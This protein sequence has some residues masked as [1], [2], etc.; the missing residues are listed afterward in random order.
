VQTD[1]YGL[2]ATLHQM[3]TGHDPADSPFHFAPLRSYPEVLQL[4]LL[5]KQLVE[6]NVSKR[7]A[8]AALVRQQLQ[9]IATHIQQRSSSL[10]S[11]PGTIPI[12]AI[13]AGHVM[14]SPPGSRQAGSRAAARTIVPQ[15]NTLFT[16]QGHRSRITSLAW[17][18]DGRC[19]ASSSY[20]KTARLWDARN[21]K[22]V[23]LYRGHRARVNALAWSPDGRHLA[24][25][26]S[27]CS[28]QI[29]EAASGSHIFTYR[30]HTTEVT[31]LAWSPDGRYLAS[32]DASKNV[33]VW[34]LKPQRTFS[35]QSTHAGSIAALGW[36]PDGRRLACA[37]ANKTLQ[38]WDPLKTQRSGFLLNLLT[39]ART[40]ILYT[41][42]N[43]HIQ[44]V[45][46]SPDGRHIASGG[47]DKTLQIWDALTGRRTFLY[48]NR[49]A[50]INTVAWSPDQTLLAF[51]SND[52][53][54]QVWNVT[55]RKFIATY[56]GHIHYVTSLAWSPDSRCIS[57][58]SVDRTI[59]VWTVER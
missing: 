52:R 50:T 39:S 18:P 43:G 15:K 48:S 6:I 34:Q 56:Q 46:W 45:H 41:G 32:G 53:T 27:D 36:S 47:T 33:Q 8:S 51:G 24:S 11:G 37:G 7:P 59:Q 35:I 12:G 3:L 21:G 57:S 5:L 54:V 42:H 29:W 13:S 4:A 14:P 40:T 58:A 31:A 55:S 20:D 2:G 22:Q 10:A 25:A 23:L 26:S 28:V 38:V 16:C 1:L 9:E 44:T 49:F 19:L 17:S 30:G